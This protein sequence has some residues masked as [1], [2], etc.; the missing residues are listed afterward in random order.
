MEKCEICE[1]ISRI[2]EMIDF[3][4]IEPNEH[5]QL[6]NNNNV[7]VKVVRVR[8]LL[9]L[10]NYW[11]IIISCVKLCISNFKP[12]NHRNASSAVLLLPFK[13]VRDELIVL[14]ENLIIAYSC[15]PL[16]TIRKSTSKSSNNFM[17]RK[18]IGHARREKIKRFLYI[19]FLFCLENIPDKC[20][21]E[22]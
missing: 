12:N 5:H 10:V 22:K 20:K 21:M 16:I 2:W 7:S 19:F 13:Q 1:I 18:W 15:L 9:R 17:N 11:C 4:W 8:L 14:N 3:F 6:S